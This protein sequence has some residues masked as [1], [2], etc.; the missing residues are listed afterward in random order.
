[1][2]KVLT[3]IS[4]QYYDDAKAGIA[5]LFITIWAKDKEKLARKNS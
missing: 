1:L 4:L 2:K 5:T 3:L